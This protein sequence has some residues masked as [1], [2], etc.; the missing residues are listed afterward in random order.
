MGSNSCAI[1]IDNLSFAFDQ[2]EILKSIDLKIEKGK[3]YSILGPNGSGKTTLVKNICR[4]LSSKHGS[5]YI[6]DKDIKRLGNKEMAKEVSLVPQNT[7]VE[8]DF[9]ALD[10]VL[11]GRTPY[12]SRFSKESEEDFKIARAAMEATNTWHLRSKSINS[13]SGGERQRVIVARAITQDTDIILLD[14]PISSLDIY[15]QVEILNAIKKLNS[16]KKVTIIAV[17]H[18]LNMA[19]A[20]SDE[21]IMMHKGKVYTQ[22]SPEEVLIDEKVKEVY[23]IDVHVIKNPVSGKPHVITII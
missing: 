5:I 23:G 3:F 19:A 2:E 16:N 7:L 8:F 14:E 21:I 1:N 20:Y 22:G 11:M 4:T 9:S 10:I 18:D 6:G 12:I 13:L 17:L 15:H